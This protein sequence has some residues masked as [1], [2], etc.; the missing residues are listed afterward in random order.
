MKKLTSYLQKNCCQL[1]VQFYH[2]LF[3]KLDVRTFKEFFSDEKKR[4]FPFTY[5]L[6]IFCKLNSV[7]SLLKCILLS[8]DAQA[9]ML[10]LFDIFSPRNV[11]KYKKSDNT[12]SS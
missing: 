7:K 6:M 8:S 3:G 4:F 12:V 10:L 2:Y 1:S 11:E 9:R 5:S